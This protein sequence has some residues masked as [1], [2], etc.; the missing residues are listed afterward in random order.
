MRRR[1]VFADRA[2]DKPGTAFRE[3]PP[4]AND[5]R[6]RGI[7]KRVLTEQQWADERDIG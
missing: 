6:H 2:Q 3:E 5:Q 7:D 1:V 4:D